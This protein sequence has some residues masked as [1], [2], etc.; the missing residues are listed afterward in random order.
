[1]GGV[2]RG[3]KGEAEEESGDRVRERDIRKG[4]AG[5]IDGQGAGGEEWEEGKAQRRDG[6]GAKTEGIQGSALEPRYQVEEP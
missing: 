5:E 2:V 1:M 6:G 4:S 3:R